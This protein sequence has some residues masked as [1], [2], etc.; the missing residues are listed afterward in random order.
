MQMASTITAWSEQSDLALRL[1]EQARHPHRL[2]S[3]TEAAPEIDPLLFF[4]N[5]RRLTTAAFYW[6]QVAEA[7]VIVGIGSVATFRGS[8]QDRFQEMT[9]AWGKLL[10]DWDKSAHHRAEE[11]WG[12]GPTLLGGFAF[13]PLQSQRNPAWQSFGDGI[14]TLPAIQLTRVGN[15]TYMTYNL[16]QPGGPAD[17][18]GSRSPAPL[19]QS[20]DYLIRLRASLLRQTSSE[21]AIPQISGAARLEEIVAAQEWRQIVQHATGAIRSGAFQ[22]TVLAREVLAHFDQ[23]IAIEAT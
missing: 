23:P 5:G 10:Q 21:S 1:R 11:P 15:Q 22:K 17:R 7:F 18:N 16:I 14:M 19:D 3:F 9:E 12:G 4:E 20:I 6:E 8:G 2:V 13:D